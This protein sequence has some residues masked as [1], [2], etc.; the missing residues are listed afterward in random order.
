MDG[1]IK[2]GANPA[3]T[4]N[5]IFCGAKKTMAIENGIANQHGTSSPLKIK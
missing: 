3:W 2:T 5:R 4:V 1:N